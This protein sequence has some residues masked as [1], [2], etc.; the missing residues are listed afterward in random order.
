[1]SAGAARI[2]EVDS[3]RPPTNLQDEVARIYEESR[4][5]L[6]RYVALIGLPREQAQEICQEAFLRLYAALSNGQQIENPRAWAFTVARN[7]ALTAR[8]SA[9]PFAALDPDTE[10]RLAAASPTPEQSVLDLERQ[11]RLRSAVRLLSDQQRH[12]LHLRTK[13]FRYR[14]IAEIIGVSTSS[15]GEAIERAV[16]RLRKALYD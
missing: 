1:M 3:D 9:A 6:Y 10:S 4:D 14:E 5:D 2:I 13:G 15:V 12:C 11:R 16:K 7:L 8:G